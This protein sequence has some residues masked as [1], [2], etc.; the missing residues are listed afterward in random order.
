MEAPTSLACE[1][2]EDA[3]SAVRP[4]HVKT[5]LLTW[6]LLLIIPHAGNRLSTR[7]FHCV[8]T[9][10]TLATRCSLMEKMVIS[11]TVM[12][13][14]CKGLVLPRT[15]PKEIRTVAV[16]KSA[17]IILQDKDRKTEIRK[18]RAH[19]ITVNQGLPKPRKL[20]KSH[21]YLKMLI[22][23]LPWCMCQ[24]PCMRR[25]HCSPKAASSRLTPTLLK[26][27]R[28][29]NVMRNPK[30]M[31]IMTWTSWNTERTRGEVSS[32]A[33]KITGPYFVLQ[34]SLYPELNV[35]MKLNQIN[36]LNDALLSIRN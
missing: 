4:I 32:A 6:W 36:H 1:R 14:S 21:L 16:L 2:R 33:G 9:L 35:D 25:P 7:V 31:K 17:L 24:K 10:R 15:A 18:W 11:S 12:M 8:L 20:Q 23:I 34:V 29:R 19:H 22:V 5:N 26:P 30:P 3:V 13:R 27:Y 28:L